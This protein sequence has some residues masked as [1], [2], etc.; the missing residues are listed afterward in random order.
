MT[1][2]YSRGLLSSSIAFGAVLLPVAAY[3]QE[4]DVS[5]GIEEIIVTA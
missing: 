4:A 2:G 3:A 1:F 5:E